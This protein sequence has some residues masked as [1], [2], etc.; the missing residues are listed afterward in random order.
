M[1]AEAMNSLA[2]GINSV[3]CVVV[4][5]IFGLIRRGKNDVQNAAES[6]KTVRWVSV[7]VGL[8]VV[9]SSTL[10][11]S[12]QGNLLEL[13]YKIVNLLTVPLFGLFV[14]AIFVRRATSFGAFAGAL[15]GFSTVAIINFWPEITG[16]PEPPVS[17]LWAMPLALPVQ[18]LVGMVASFIP[19]G[20]ARPMLSQ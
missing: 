15:A 14:L 5:D 8:L 19:I 2:S 12:V 10:V 9:A 7:C 11:R 17:F 6:L 18:L 16:Q 4:T 1:L 3:S 13:S 20:R